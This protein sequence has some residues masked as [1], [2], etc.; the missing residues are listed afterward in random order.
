MGFDA[1]HA[2]AARSDF[3]ALARRIDGEPIA[4]FD[5]PGGTQVPQTVIDAVSRV[6][7]ECNVNLG[8]AFETSREAGQVVQAARAAAADFL[9]ASTPAQISLGA[10]MTTLNFALARAL[11]RRLQ[12]GDEIIVTA[13]DHE[14]NRGPWLGLAERGAVVQEARIRPDGTLD[15]DHLASLVSPRTKIIAAGIASNALGTVTPF[16]PIRELAQAYGA[17]TVVDAVHYAAH[18]PLDFEALG[19]DF[20][21]CSAYKF[22]GPHVGVLCSRAGLLDTLEPDRLSVQYQEAPHRIETGTPNIAALAGISAAIDYLAGLGAGASRRERLLDAM[23]SLADYE[24]GLAAQ[25]AAGLDDLPGVHCHGPAL[26]TWPRAPTVSF[27]RARGVAPLAAELARQGIQVWHGHFYARRV[28]ESLGLTDQG[29]LLRVGFAL[30][31]TPNEVDRLL[32]A[33][34]VAC[35][36]GL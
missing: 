28:I 20:L 10:N 5:A 19:C 14:A 3:P 27:A 34:R 8:G 6:Y 26:A 17:L 23:Q 25:Y 29:G 15:I 30:Y 2:A 9:G 18:L 12:P 11:G 7:R 4:W 13:L 22:Y 24:H 16:A 35:A 33:L 31:N 36:D 32:A 21:L 1:A